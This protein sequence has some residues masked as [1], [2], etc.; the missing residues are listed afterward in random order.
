LNGQDKKDLNVILERME[1]ADKDRGKIHDDIKFIKENMFNPH[2][3]LWSETKLNSQ[4][5][6]D[7][8]KWRYP[9][10][11]GLISLVIKN[12]WDTIVK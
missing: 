10:G 7:S 5:R 2:Q 3:G 4:F 6:E 12:V 1:Q 9:I 8:K 11:V